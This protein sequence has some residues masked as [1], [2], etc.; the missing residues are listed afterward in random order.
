[1][2]KRTVIFF[3][4]ATIFTAL[5]NPAH[6][7]IAQVKGPWS[8]R[9][10]LDMLLARSQHSCVRKR[11]F[12]VYMAQWLHYHMPYWAGQEAE[13]SKRCT[14]V[15]SK[16]SPCSSEEDQARVPPSASKRAALSASRHRWPEFEKLAKTQKKT[17]QQRHAVA[18]ESD[19]R[20][21]CSSHPGSTCP[22]LSPPI[23]RQPPLWAELPPEGDPRPASARCQPI[24]SARA[25]DVWPLLRPGRAQYLRT[26]QR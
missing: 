21:H 23:P 19:K 7:V 22:P 13:A 11:S 2:R 16:A 17:T 1:M 12:Q 14:R 4:Q 15:G 24:R 26:H 9:R 25:A 8:A 20:E 5:I 10:A 3:S 18:L 6:T